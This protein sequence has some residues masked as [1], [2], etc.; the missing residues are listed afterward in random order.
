LRLREKGWRIAVAPDSRVLHKV[1]ASTG[2]NRALLDRFETASTLR[3][4][5]LHSP[6]PRLAMLLFLTARFA[7]R[8]LRLQFSRCRSVWLGIQDYRKMAFR[9]GSVQP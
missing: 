8:C 5:R 9:T 3:V 6:V 2:G 4:L 7:R 1:N